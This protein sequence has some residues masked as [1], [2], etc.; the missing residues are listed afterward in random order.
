VG[1]GLS[2][3]IKYLRLTASGAAGNGLGATIKYLRRTT[4]AAAGS[5][6]GTT[7]KYL[8]DAAGTHLGT[9]INYLQR[10]RA[11]RRAAARAPRLSTCA[12]PRVSATTIKYLRRTTRQRPG[13]H[14]QVP[15]TRNER[16]R[17][18]RAEPIP[19]ITDVPIHHNRPAFVFLWVPPPT[20]SIIA[21]SRSGV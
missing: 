4:S 13:H 14:V 3:T 21:L 1:N 10:T 5:G 17:G 2:T 20:T 6:L 12:A 15:A 11:R 8:S 16:R 9:T 7:I 18:Q 19:G